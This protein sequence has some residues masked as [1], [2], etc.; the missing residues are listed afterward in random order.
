MDHGSARP[1]PSD[2]QGMRQQFEAG[3]RAGRG[4]GEPATGAGD[5][6]AD[7]SSIVERVS[8]FL[9]RA[10]V[11]AA[12]RFLNARTRFRFTGVF[13]VEPPTLRNIRL[14]DRENPTLNVS[15][16]V[17]DLDIG[18][19]GIACATLVPFQTADARE[20]PRLQ[21]HPARNSMISYAGVPIRMANGV[22]W[23]TLCHYDVRPRLIPPDE[24]SILLAA[25]P[26]FAAW[27]TQQITP[28]RATL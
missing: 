14:V 16:A 2:D 12:L 3:F 6:R 25:A 9:R 22:A 23:G 11:D 20:D 24:L 17:A 4:T 27:V 13:Q 28:R 8:A 15:G 10:D 1:G 21:S 7:S 19:C 5:S 26:L 18:Y